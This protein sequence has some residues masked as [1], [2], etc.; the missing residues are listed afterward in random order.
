[1]Q[2]AVIKGTG[3][4]TGLPV[5]VRLTQREGAL[6]LRA[7][8]IEAGLDELSVVSTLRA[9][10]VE[11]KGGSLRVHMVEHLFA[12]LGG[13]GVRDGVTIEVEGP[14][15]PL[16]DGA[17]AA[18]CEA[19]ECLSLR[20]APPKTRVLLAAVIHVGESRYEF[21]PGNRIEVAV[22]IEFGDGRIAAEADWAGSPE[23]FRSR[24]AP[25][26][27]FA[28]ARDLDELFRNGL[29]RCVDPS[30][31][32]VIGDEVVHCAGRPFSPDEP[33]RHKLLDLVGDAYLCGGPPL[34]SVRAFRPG[35]AAN[36]QA[37][38]EALAEGVLVR[39]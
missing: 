10:S 30:S 26:R 15:M 20:A 5:T 24:I 16:L 17:A 34:G 38:R 9:T 4:H 28:M 1:M 6:R 21:L 7:R 25:A 37:F 32:V 31:V 11:A 18:W 35:H 27:T 33:A 8:G 36:A 22:R 39:V 14:E 19:I 3:L 12:A 29:A 23:D 2:S 13:L